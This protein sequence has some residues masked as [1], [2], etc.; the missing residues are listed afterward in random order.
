M[1]L[2]NLVKG[3]KHS[4][5]KVNWAQTFLMADEGKPD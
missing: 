5:R 1:L 3:G 4:A 2:L